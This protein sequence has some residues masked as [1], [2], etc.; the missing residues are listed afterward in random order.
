MA[1][2]HKSVPA[3]NQTIRALDPQAKLEP[4]RSLPKVAFVPKRKKPLEQEIAEKTEQYTEKFV[5]KTFGSL[6]VV[7]PVERNEKKSWHV[8]CRCLECG[9]EAMWPI[10]VLKNHKQC[11]CGHTHKARNKRASFDSN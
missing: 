9:T 5:G 7:G 6:F 10:V 1:R 2:R 4:P 3:L 11:T 8:L